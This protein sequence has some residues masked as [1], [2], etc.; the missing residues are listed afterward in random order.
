MAD[1][2]CSRK[3]DVIR[4]IAG[5]LVHTYIEVPDEEVVRLIFCRQSHP[6]GYEGYDLA[7][8][9]TDKTCTLTIYFQV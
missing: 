3:P 6:P 8:G 4:K 1:D 7:P 9:S 5:Q 2:P